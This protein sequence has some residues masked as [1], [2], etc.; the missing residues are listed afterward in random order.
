MPTTTRVTIY[1]TQVDRIFL[2][3]GDVWDYMREVGDEHYRWAS[4]YAPT[5]TY[6]LL[7]QMAGPFVMPYNGR[8]GVRYSVGNYAP[9]ANFV[10]GGTTGPIYGKTEL[11]GLEGTWLWVRPMPYSW[12]PA[13]GWFGWVDGQTANPWI[14]RAWDTVAA[15]KLVL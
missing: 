7:S 10:H 15:S 12:Y 4:I 11:E 5:R 1:D 2:P 8:R 9:Y 14:R 13:G 3:G 6:F